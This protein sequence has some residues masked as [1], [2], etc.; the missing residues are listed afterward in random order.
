MPPALL[1]HLLAD[2]AGNP[3][4]LTA[5][6]T[7]A[8]FGEGVLPGDSSKSFLRIASTKLFAASAAARRMHTG[9]ADHTVLVIMVEIWDIEKRHVRFFQHDRQAL[10]VMPF[11]ST[12]RG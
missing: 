8:A 11:A 2:G 12:S 4:G 1:P 3:R 10:V 9:S 5:G 6:M 7:R